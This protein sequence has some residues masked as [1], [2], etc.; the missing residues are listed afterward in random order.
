M[1]LVEIFEVPEV[2][3]PDALGNYLGSSTVTLSNCQ[4]AANN[5][6]FG[7]F[8]S[9][10]VAGQDGSLFTGLA[11]FSG[12]SVVNLNFAG[13]VT[14]GADL[15]GSFTFSSLVGSGNGT[16]TGSVGT[17]SIALNFSGQVTNGERCALNGSAAGS[18]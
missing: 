14:A 3:I 2:T 5:G 1:G 9:V 18:Q 6:S 13:T 16:F 7:F 17:N 10:N 12:P 8:S 4:N 15:M 11:T